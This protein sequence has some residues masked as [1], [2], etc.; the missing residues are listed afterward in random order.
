ML[1]MVEC[2][3]S[4]AAHEQAWNDYYSGQKLDQVLAVPG[5]RTSQRFK[6]IS[7]NA[8]PYFAI[9][10]IDS[11]EV[12]LG[13]FYRSRGG[14]SFDATYQPYI[15]NWKRRLYTGLDRALAIPK[16]ELLAV[17]DRPEESTAASVDFIWLT[18]AGLD[19]SVPRRGIARIDRSQADVIAKT[20][21]HVITIYAP[22]TIQRQEPPGKYPIIG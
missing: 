10:T 7:D 9:H 22:L 8:A 19:S 14:G 15:R 11:P 2:A 16:N 1:Y 6:S 13:E 5:F 3:F 21:Q 4:D 18:A 12:L 17:S 20:H